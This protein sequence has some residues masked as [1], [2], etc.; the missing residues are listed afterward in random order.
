MKSI[1]KM[2]A[3][4]VLALGIAGGAVGVASASTHFNL[5][6]KGVIKS[7]SEKKDQITIVSDKK[8]ITF[9]DTTKTVV[10]LNGK[11]SKIDD[12]KA[13][14]DVTISYSILLRIASSI[15]A[16]AK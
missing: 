10:T 12:L 8:D 16:T 11:S 13:G 4:A 5:A 14:D 7:I 1:P 6:S 3:P 9:K 2:I 15:E